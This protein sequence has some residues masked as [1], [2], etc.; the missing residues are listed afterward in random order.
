MANLSGTAFEDKYNN[1]S[2]GQYKDNT[3]R[4]ITPARLRLL[5]TD[6]KDSFL[7]RTDDVLDEDDMA[8]NSNVKVPTQQSVKV[9]ADDKVGNGVNPGVTSVAPSQQAVI[10]YV[11]AEI[12]A[13]ALGIVTS[14]KAPV[15]VATTANITLSGEQTIDGVLTSG[16]RVLVKDQSTG[17]QNGIYVTA[18]GAWSRSADANA[19]SELEG[20]AITVQ[21]GSTQANTTWVQ[22]ADGITLGSTSIAWSQLGT[23][24]GY[25]AENVA[26]KATS[27][28]TINNTLYPTVQAV[29]DRITAQ[30][31]KVIQIAC[32]DEVTPITAATNKVKFR[33]PYAMTVTA[34]RA[35]LSTAQTSG[36]IFTVDINEGGSTILS[37]KLT[38]DNG[39]TTST[40]AATAAVIS[41]ASLADDAEITVDVDQV[42]DN[43]AKGLKVTLI[44]S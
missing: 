13:A 18:A 23:S 16:S 35:S 26:N 12:A 10:D 42:G 7:N 24:L 43:T 5:P 37:T 21:Q 6:V 41:D 9:Y 25:T 44:G 31:P 33:M 15:V 36:S 39:E 14:W 30:A 27:F 8:S 34:V 32:S 38:I 17:S 11:A 3:T 22:T 4:D 20:A 19:A 29:S 2:T 1:A 28:G 40:T